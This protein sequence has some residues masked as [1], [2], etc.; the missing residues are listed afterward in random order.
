[1]RNFM[2]RFRKNYSDCFSLITV[3]T[4]IICFLFM[5]DTGTTAAVCWLA[6][7]FALSFITRPFMPMK[8]LKC[9]SGWF[10]VRSCLG[11]FLC[12][13]VAWTVSALGL[14][15]FSDAIC[16]ASFFMIA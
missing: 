5:K 13:Y 11:L 6:V 9:T 7:V 1:M 12:F 16:Y 2:D 8:A 15:E 14:C 3:V 4:V 10:G